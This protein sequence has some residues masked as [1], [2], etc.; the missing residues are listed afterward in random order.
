MCLSSAGHLTAQPLGGVG[1]HVL[2]GK[3]RVEKGAGE[4]G[5]SPGV[6]AFLRPS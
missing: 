1:M 2:G 6:L 3:G 4:E 5:A